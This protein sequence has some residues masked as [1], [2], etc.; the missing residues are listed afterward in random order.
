MIIMLTNKQTHR[1]I[2]IPLVHMHGGM[3]KGDTVVWGG[4][5]VNHFK[6]HK[7][8]FMLPCWSQFTRIG[9]L[10]V[11]SYYYSSGGVVCF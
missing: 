1:M 2:A 10:H 11:V 7:I 4:H 5:L 8:K 6:V 3:E 9:D